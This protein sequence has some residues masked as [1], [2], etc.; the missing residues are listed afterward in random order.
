CLAAFDRVAAR[1]PTL[2]RMV[3]AIPA[4]GRRRLP[5][6]S[7]AASSS[8]REAAARVAYRHARSGNTVAVVAAVAM[9]A[10]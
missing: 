10:P 8:A 1:A 3:G 7:M 2:R 9:A 4:T 5:D 6:G